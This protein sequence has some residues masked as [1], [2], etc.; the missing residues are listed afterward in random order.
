MSPPAQ[1]ALS[2]APWIMTARID[3]SVAHSASLSSSARIMSRVS[4]FICCGR[5]SVALPTPSAT[6]NSTS[7]NKNCLQREMFGRFLGQDG[8]SVKRI[9]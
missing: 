1:N 6:S 4:A 8:A 9:A 5:F 2:P 3:V 7:V